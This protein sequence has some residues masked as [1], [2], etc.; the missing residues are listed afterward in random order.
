MEWQRV[1]GAQM[2]KHRHLRPILE[3]T[4]IGSEIEL[5][6]RGICPDCYEYLDD[7]GRC[8]CERPIYAR[9]KKPRLRLVKQGI[10]TVDPLLQAVER[11]Q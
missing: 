3:N 5:R 4:A 7:E 10:S 2:K 6:T 9:R 11:G 8:E 1:G